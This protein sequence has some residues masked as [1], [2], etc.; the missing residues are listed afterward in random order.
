MALVVA[1]GEQ[2][3]RQVELELVVAFEHGG[4]LVGEFRTGG[5]I[6]VE[7]RHFVFVLVGHQLEQVARHR[8]G[9]AQFRR[10]VHH[11]RFDLAHLID[12]GVVLL[13][14]RGVLVAGQEFDTARDHF[15]QV[16]RALEFDHLRRLALAATTRSSAARSCAARRP[17]AKACWLKATETPFNSMARNKRRLGQRHPALLPGIAEHEHVGGDG[18]AHQRGGD[19]AG[20]DEIDVRA[21]AGGADIALGSGARKLPVGI[22][23]R[24]RRSA[25][26][27]S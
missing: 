19:L 16:R 23:G 14:I 12:K 11:S 22:A 2:R 9:Q 4:D 3:R 21:A 10:A 25:Y 18:V 8:F 6:R 15:I 20:V 24:R 5:G 7:P 17:Q 27:S 1:F 26:G 13:R